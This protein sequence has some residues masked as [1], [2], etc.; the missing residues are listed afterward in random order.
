M[1]EQFKILCE[2]FGLEHYNDFDWGKDE[3]LSEQFQ[4]VHKEIGV[5]ILP[6]TNPM[7]IILNH[8]YLQDDINILERML[9]TEEAVDSGTS[10]GF[11]IDWD[12]GNSSYF[13]EFERGDWSDEGESREIFEYSY[14]ESGTN[15]YEIQTKNLI[16][17]FSHIMPFAEHFNFCGSEKKKKH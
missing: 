13:R 6:N 14:G 16:H 9:K 8:I 5:G 11:D 10:F 4:I 7:E 15:Y 3:Y 2:I 17:T 12:T 1:D